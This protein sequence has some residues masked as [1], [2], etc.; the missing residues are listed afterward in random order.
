MSSNLGLNDDFS[1]CLS[2]EIGL[3]PGTRFIRPD[4]ATMLLDRNGASPRRPGPV[5]ENQHP[6]ARR[7]CCVHPPIPADV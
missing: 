3:I 1:A 2:G 7:Q 6:A 5:A 4:Y